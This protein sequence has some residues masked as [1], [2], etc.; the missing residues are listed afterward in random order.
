M[1]SKYI[2]GKK[3]LLDAIN[4]NL[5]IEHVF[6]LKNSF[7]DTSILEKNKINYSYKE[8][9]FFSQNNFYKKETIAFTINK[10]NNLLSFE[11]LAKKL[12]KLDDALVL[13]LDEIQDAGN[14]GAILRSADAFGVDAI[15][16]KKNNQVSP[17]H[18][19]AI[20]NS[21]NA[22]SYLTFCEVTNISQTIEKLKKM[23]FWIYSSSLTSTS[24]SYSDEQYPNKTVFIVGNENNGVSKLVQQKSDSLIHINQYGNVQS[25]NVSVATGIL[26]SFFR[27]KHPKK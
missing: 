8:L 9:S 18:T 12:D 14:M 10:S 11:E 6:I 15:I 1:K 13:I 21:T 22:V 16:F 2:F 27:I 20:K 26:L 24:H 19:I 7:F 17:F 23:N 25:L 3:A 4:N 5:N